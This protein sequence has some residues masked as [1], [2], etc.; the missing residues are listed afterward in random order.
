M[1]QS[2]IIARGAS[3]CEKL[4]VIEETTCVVHV[5]DLKTIFIE[6]SLVVHWHDGTD[7]AGLE[8]LVLCSLLV[9]RVVNLAARIETRGSMCDFLYLRQYLI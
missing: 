2:V 1:V 7:R 4:L 5:I 8:R 9:V 6:L 3:T